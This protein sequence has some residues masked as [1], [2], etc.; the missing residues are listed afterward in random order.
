MDGIVCDGCGAG[1][2]IESDVRYLVK[3]EVYAAYDPLEITREDLARDHRQ[4]MARLL[5]SMSRQ[6]PQELQDQVHR[7]FQ[8][9]LCPSCQ[10]RYLEDPLR[11]GPSRSG[12]GR[13][14][15]EGGER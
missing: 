13:P 3:I 1:L 4:E 12:G 2:L 5:E 7:S 15:G 9:D 6:D 14:D 10:R 8:F 11:L